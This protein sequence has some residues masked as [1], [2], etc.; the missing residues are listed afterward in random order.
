MLF[1]LSESES[2]RTALKRVLDGFDLPTFPELVARALRLRRDPSCDLSVIAD[3]LQRDARVTARLL[4]PTNGGSGLVS[5][6]SRRPPRLGP[7]RPFR[8]RV[9]VVGLCREAWEALLPLGS[10]RRATGELLSGVRRRPVGWPESS[11]PARSENASRLRCFRTWPSPCCCARRG[12]RVPGSPRALA[13]AVWRSRATR[14]RGFQ[15]GPRRGGRGHGRSLELPGLAGVGDCLTPRDE[16]GP[17]GDATG[18]AARRGG[19]PRPGGSS[20][21][22]MARPRA[23]GR[24]SA[25]RAGAGV[26][27]GGRDRETFCSASKS[28]TCQ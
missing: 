5:K 1:W 21:G 12:G 22:G 20:G 17:A 13:K 6:G 10:T 24:G 2:P 18:R 14:A 19:S 23:A 4:P 16:P 25:F 27:R 26:W 28:V 15:L 9:D 11:I 7:A 8:G 3:A